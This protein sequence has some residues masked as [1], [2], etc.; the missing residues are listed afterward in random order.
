VSLLEGQTAIITGAGRGFGRAVAELLASLGAHV[1]VASRNAPQLD[2]VVARIKASKGRALAYAADVSDERQVQD[3]VFNTERW[4]G[5]PTI[6]VNNAGVV[7]PMAPLARTDA[8]SWLRHIAVNVGGTYLATRAVLP[9]MLES[10]HG[11][12]VNISSGAAQKP[13]AGWTAYCTSKAAVEQFTRALAVE[14]DGTGV[15]V[16]ALRPGYM[17]TTMMERIRRASESDFPRVEEYRAAH[18][19]G[20]TRDPRVPA[21]AVAYL[22]APQTKRNGEILRFGDADLDAAIAALLGG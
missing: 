5:P 14:I 17:E 2:E 21:R 7:D 15:T 10:G 12:I 16:N 20:E 19:T 11:R 4:V 18:Q 22:A 3:L 13:S 8:T 1:V 9:G 6:L